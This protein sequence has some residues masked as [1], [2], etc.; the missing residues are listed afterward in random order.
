MNYWEVIRILFLAT[1]I[2]GHLVLA[3]YMFWRS[4]R[5]RRAEAKRLRSGRRATIGFNTVQGME[6]YEMLG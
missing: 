3:A 5:I 2:G 1:F 6:R 4:L